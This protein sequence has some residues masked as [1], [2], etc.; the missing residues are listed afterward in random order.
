MRKYR[1]QFSD[2]SSTP[3]ERRY[4]YIDYYLQGIALGGSYRRREQIMH[5]VERD[6]QR[7]V[8]PETTIG[9]I[10]EVGL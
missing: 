10:R 7:R 8:I 1:V 6:Q 2:P 5:C 3:M 4:G 9:E